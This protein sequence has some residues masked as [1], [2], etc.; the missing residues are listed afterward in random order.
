MNIESSFIQYIPTPFF[1]TPFLPAPMSLRSISPVSPGGQ[2][3]HMSILPASVYVVPHTCS[4]LRDQKVAIDTLEMVIATWVFI[5]E[6][7][8]GLCKS[9]KCC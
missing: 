4:A 9:S 2:L 3:M 5:I 8:Y 1:L 7:R 6:H